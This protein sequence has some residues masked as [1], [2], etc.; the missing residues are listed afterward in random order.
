MTSPSSDIMFHIIYVYK[1]IKDI[2]FTKRSRDVTSLSPVIIYSE[3]VFAK[4]S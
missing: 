3:D 2:I 4:K 1:N